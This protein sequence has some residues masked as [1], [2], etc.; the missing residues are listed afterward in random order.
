M[1]RA[2]TPPAGIDDYGT[3]PS[4]RTDPSR[5]AGP[6]GTRARIPE[7][8]ARSGAG[9]RNGR[10]RLI[11]WLIAVVMLPIPVS[12]GK[13]GVDMV[14]TSVGTWITTNDAATGAGKNSYFTTAK[15]SMYYH[16]G[17]LK[18]YVGVP[19]TLALEVYPDVV[20]Y[21]LYPADLDAYV[22]RKLG[23]VEPRIGMGVPLGYPAHDTLAWTG[24]NTIKL[25]VGLGYRLGTFADKRVSVGGEYLLRVS[26]TDTANG[27]R[28]GRGSTAMYAVVNAKVRLSSAWA[29]TIELFPYY[30]YY[31]DVD[32]GSHS[33]GV[34]PGLG[35]SYRPTS[36]LKLGAKAG[37]GFG[38][39]GIDLENRSK[40]ITGS[41]GL[42]VYLY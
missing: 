33:F 31:T 9:T 42:D 17:W 41:V 26:L 5:P 2:K 23:P 38:G 1:T 28:V 10:Y 27:G 39:S 7:P 21:A 15:L 29:C 16:A 22:G 11:A 37:F 32:W 36:R 25:L 40:V 24:T 34:V 19:A 6:N 35:L 13:A 12:A 3:M 4:S 8:I 20:K 30:S 18:G 14:I